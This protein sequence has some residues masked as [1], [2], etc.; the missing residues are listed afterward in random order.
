MHAKDLCPKR[1]DG[2]FSLGRYYDLLL[3]GQEN[4]LDNDMALQHHSAG[5]TRTQLLIFTHAIEVVKNYGKSMQVGVAVAVAVAVAV[6][7]HMCSKLTHLFALLL[8]CS[9]FVAM[10]VHSLH[11]VFI[12]AV[13]SVWPQKFARDSSS[14]VD[15]M[16]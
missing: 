8:P 15:G 12:G 2:W 13:A 7:F 9:F 4:N 5:A 6:D 16:V 3:K 10:V 11:L 14:H 1:E